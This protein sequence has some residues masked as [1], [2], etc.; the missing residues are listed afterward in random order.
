VADDRVEDE[1]ARY[2][3]LVHVLDEG[4]VFMDSTG[5][6]VLANEAAGRILGVRPDDLIGSNTFDPR[7]PTTHADGTPV[8]RDEFP[9]VATL[10]TGKPHSNVTMHMR[11]PD[12]VYVWLTVNARPVFEEGGTEPTGVVL[13]FTDITGQRDTEAQRM[14]SLGRL[15][16]G[17]AHDFN[18]LLGV[19]L[20]YASVIAK[21]AG[22]DDQIAE[23]ARRIQEA[24]DHGTDLVRQ[25]LLFSRQEARVARRFDLR[26]V[27]DEMVELIVRPFAPRIELDV[28]HSA[29]ECIVA[30]DRGQLGQVLLNLLLNARDAI[31]SVG[32]IT[33]TTTK[34]AD[35]SEVIPGPVVVVAVEDDGCGMT[36]EVQA[37]AFEP[38][39][40]TKVEGSGLGLSAA[41]GSI[42]AV[43]GRITI[44]S[45][46]D[47]G[48]I[49]RIVLPFDPTGGS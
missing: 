10:A 32:H 9:A 13:S 34:H 25:L 15:A 6:T 39:F 27:V 14:E 41:Y 7:F 42:T 46:L 18:N 24:A 17:I 38:F 44:E 22:P 3:E 31:D 43:G 30:A 21:R 16:G 23:D 45:T 2:R 1:A 5:T 49:V 35:G 19:I 37:R 36:S 20:N 26:P 48:S 33:V 8:E 4:V 47:V 40:T 28:R 29:E 11:R 12:G